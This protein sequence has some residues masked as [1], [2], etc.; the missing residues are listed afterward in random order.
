MTY[1]RSRRLVAE[2]LGTA[3]LV[4]TVVG[5]GI[6]AD[7][8]SDDVAVSLMGNT[9]PTGAMLV[10]LITLLAPIS[11]AHFNPVVSLVFTLRRQL[12]VA[13]AGAY[14]AMQ[15]LGGVAG[16]LVAHAMF[17]LPLFQVAATVRTGM[18][19]WL[20]EA[21]ATFGLLLT[22]LLGLKM[23]SE[24]IPWLVGLYITA[25]YWFTAST[26]F[27]NPAVAVARAL[28]DTFAG[29]R[30]LDVPGFIVAEIA[31]AL[32]AMVVTGWLLADPAS[33][34]PSEHAS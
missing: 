12:T 16:T 34:Q 31:G 19:Q 33:A 9:I 4:S 26:S 29:I 2:G 18:G 25:A 14:I 6:M 1:D 7:R 17:D 3:L 22:I 13:D 28:S 32:L 24:A 5:S 21:T 20:A 27:A 30:P 23:R 10:V 11:G 15:I 8:L